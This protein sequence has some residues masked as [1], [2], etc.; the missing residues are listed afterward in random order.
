M[1]RVISFHDHALLNNFGL[2]LS[3]SAYKNISEESE[4]SHDF[5]ELASDSNDIS[6]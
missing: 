2:S 6:C 5:L 4:H 1:Q 3:Y